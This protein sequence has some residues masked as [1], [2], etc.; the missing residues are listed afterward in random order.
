PLDTFLILNT[1]MNITIPVV[2][3]CPCNVADQGTAS[4]NHCLILKLQGTG[5]IVSCPR[6]LLT[7]QHH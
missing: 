4:S 1:V 7:P 6:L 3:A 5:I 2:F